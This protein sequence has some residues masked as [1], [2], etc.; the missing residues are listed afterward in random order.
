MWVPRF[1][2]PNTWQLGYSLVVAD[3]VSERTP[4]PSL[5]SRIHRFGLILRYPSSVVEN[6][7]VREYI[8]IEYDHVGLIL[9]GS[10]IN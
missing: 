2:P 5:P 6:Y 8:S 3:I 7:W 4:L 1:D 9:G 10:L